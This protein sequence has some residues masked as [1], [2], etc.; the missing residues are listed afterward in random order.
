MLNLQ[1]FFNANRE[2]ARPLLAYLPQ[3]PALA[4][5]KFKE[6]VQNYIN[7]QKNQVIL[8]IGGGRQCSFSANKPVTTRLICLDISQEQL[9]QNQDAD[10]RLLADATQEIPLP[11]NSVDLVVSR[12]V[13]EHLDSPQAFLH[14]SYRV[15]KPG[16]YAIHVFPCKFAPFAMINRLLPSALGRKVLFKFQ[17]GMQGKGGFP[18]YY[19][20]CYYTGIKKIFS[21]AGFIIKDM[22][23]FHSQS[24]YF[25]FF[26]PMFLVV[27]LYEI[28]TMPVKDLAS[29]M[30]VVAQKPLLHKIV[31]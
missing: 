21:E 27:A 11:D 7:L 19:R 29:F 3:G 9:D 18:A 2:I 22:Q 1:N 31:A 10:V 26:L 28:V 24:V 20:K 17:P 16:G 8:D 6:V 14:H 12:A 30:L 13:M 4:F 5:I 23:L 15:M 25:D